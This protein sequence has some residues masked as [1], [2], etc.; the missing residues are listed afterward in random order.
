MHDEETA[1]SAAAAELSDEEEVGVEETVEEYVSY[2]TDGEEEGEAEEYPV[3]ADAL[4]ETE[5]T[6]TAE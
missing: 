3:V 5:E 6:G 1:G 2:G 4:C